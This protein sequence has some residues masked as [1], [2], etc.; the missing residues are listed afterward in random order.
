MQLF[1]ELPHQFQPR[2][3]PAAFEFIIA[4]FLVLFGAKQQLLESHRGGFVH[5]KRPSAIGSLFDQRD[6]LGFGFAS[7][8]TDAGQHDAAQLIP[9]EA[10]MCAG[11]EAQHPAVF[12]NVVAVF[13]AFN[14]HA[15]IDRFLQA[16][17]ATQQCRMD[18]GVVND[19]P[20]AA[21]KPVQQREVVAVKVVVADIPRVEVP[22][23]VPVLVPALPFFFRVF[24]IFLGDLTG[25]GPQLVKPVQ[26]AVPV[27]WLQR[28]P[29][30]RFAQRGGLEAQAVVGHVGR[31]DDGILR[32][33]VELGVQVVDLA[34]VAFA[35]PLHE[36]DD[37]LR[38]GA[39]HAQVAHDLCICALAAD[40][41]ASTGADE[42]GRDAQRGFCC[43]EV[44]DGFGQVVFVQKHGRFLGDGLRVDV[45]VC[46]V[47]G[48]C[49]FFVTGLFGYENQI[50][51]GS[52]L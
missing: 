31:A 5:V 12:L 28:E 26:A 44:Q 49:G 16:A 21:P 39:A 9:L 20:R 35:E 42:G 30:P 46:G 43:Q 6:G 37:L 24:Q 4:Q 14:A 22:L 18:G 15:I 34:H 48:V 13:V 27:G 33:D 2:F 45:G 3:K 23:A 47:H 25:F 51:S 1:P 8:A 36:H 19:F 11:L 32:T 41:A 7:V 38:V 40:E 50:L 29:V 10:S 52:G 17:P